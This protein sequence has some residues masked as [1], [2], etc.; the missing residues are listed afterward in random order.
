M[1]A[2]LRQE[3]GLPSLEQVQG[4]LSALP[5]LEPVLRRLVRVFLSGLLRLALLFYA[6]ALG[7]PLPVVTPQTSYPGECNVW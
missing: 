5:D 1:W 7:H 3:F 4:R 6:V 2:A